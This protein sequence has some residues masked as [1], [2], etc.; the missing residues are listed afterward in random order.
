MGAVN[1]IE[2]LAEFIE[3]RNEL[4]FRAEAV[5]RVRG[6]IGRADDEDGRRRALIDEV[7]KL[8]H[9]P[10]RSPEGRIVLA[11]SVLRGLRAAT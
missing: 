7:L 1:R 5:R 10:G 3:A 9:C 4:R 11:E 2:V 6:K 8:L